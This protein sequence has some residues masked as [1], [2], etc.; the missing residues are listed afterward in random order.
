M[1][2][3][4]RSLEELVTA[5]ERLGPS[6]HLCMS[7]HTQ[8]E[9][10]AA[11]VPFIRRGLERREQCVYLTDEDSRPAV[12]DAM[13]SGGI[14]V[15]T[16]T[17]TGALSILR[18]QEDTYPREGPFDP[19]RMLA[20][21]RERAVAARLAGFS[22][23][24]IVGEMICVAE[25]AGLDVKRLAEFEAK[26]NDLLR[27][28]RASGLCLFDRRRFAPEVIREMIATHPLVVV[29][30]T[31]CQ[32]PLFVPPRDYLSPDWPEREVE[33]L[34]NNLRDRQR[35]E[36][37]LRETEER[38]R[39][40]ARRLLEVQE[41][42]RH[43]IAR[44]L[45]DDLGQILT[46]IKIYLQAARSRPRQRAQKL[47][48]S[49]RLVEEALEHVRETTV[50]L[51]PPVLDELGLAPALHWYVSRQAT[52][53]GL[54]FHFDVTTLEGVR[55]PPSVETTCFRVVQEA[56]TNVI[57]HARARRV[58]VKVTIA[59]DELEVVIQ[60]DG[61][62][63]DVDVAH[64]RAAVGGSLGVL[65]MEERV[66][67]A[68]GRLAIESTPDHGTTIRARFPLTREDGL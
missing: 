36:S 61:T 23:F 17:E 59:G 32:N 21:I 68:G 11:T 18:A 45:H 66:S 27:E 33:W 29:G 14:A 47:A 51:R 26:V 24:R 25:G 30:T 31:V 8:Q 56:I 64:K 9:A 5:V 7:Y 58:D 39:M 2:S 13:L 1:A 10:L 44:D 38:Y 22:A 48:E 12:L 3:E 6:D 43:K 42:E 49:V 52:Q 4:T 37:D 65:S 53:T 15:G 46:T 55:L 67:L 57:R 40:L 63:F 19:E 16:A 50:H 41:T 35:A 28:Q 34:L 20:W 54:A 60:D 62:G